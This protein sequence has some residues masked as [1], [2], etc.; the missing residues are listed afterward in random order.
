MFYVIAGAEECVVLVKS[1]S[2]DLK[3]EAM[4]S[5]R[6]RVHILRIVEL[7][8]E[9]ALGCTIGVSFQRSRKQPI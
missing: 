2:S 9:S 3:V 5:L 1:P 7:S 6:S 4:I 8:R